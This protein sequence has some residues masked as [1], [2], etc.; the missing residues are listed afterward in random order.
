M[1]RKIR[2]HRCWWRMLETKCVGDNFE[3]LFNISV[4]YQ[5]PKDVTN[6][7][8]L[9]LTSKNWQRDKVT[10]MS[11][12]GKYER[13]ACDVDKTVVHFWKQFRTDK[14]FPQSLSKIVKICS[15]VWPIFDGRCDIYLFIWLLF[16]L[17]YWS[18]LFE[19]FH[20]FGC[21]LKMKIYEMVLRVNICMQNTNI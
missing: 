15:L 2:L 16:N 9:S 3:M 1:E 20:Q 8:I 14:K 4:G 11:V 19:H 18:D 12:A 13:V 7:E 17:W 10:N 21:L 5:Q 6:I